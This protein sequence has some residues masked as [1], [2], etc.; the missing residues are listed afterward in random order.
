MNCSECAICVCVLGCSVSALI[1]AGCWKRKGN[2]SKKNEGQEK[3]ERKGKK[4]Q[5]H[6]H[7]PHAAG[8]YTPQHVSLADFPHGFREFL[9]ARMHVY[10]YIWLLFTNVCKV[11]CSTAS[12][13]SSLHTHWFWPTERE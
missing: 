8:L 5:T 3:R 7:K 11:V 1:A 13:L 9:C 4:G 2:K 12:L 6:K 10:L